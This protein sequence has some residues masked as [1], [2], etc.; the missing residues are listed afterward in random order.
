MTL[1][2]V[3]VRHSAER[4]ITGRFDGTPLTAGN[5]RELAELLEANEIPDEATV[6]F[7]RIGYGD[8]GGHYRVLVIDRRVT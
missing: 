6:H 7:D 8:H 1:L 2:E 3:N 5:I 4:R